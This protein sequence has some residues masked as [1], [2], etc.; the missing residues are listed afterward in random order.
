MW[1]LSSLLWIL[2]Q[3]PPKGLNVKVAIVPPTGCV[4]R[5]IGSQADGRLYSMPR[6]AL[7][8]YQY[9]ASFMP[10]CTVPVV[11]DPATLT[12]KTDGS[13]SITGG[14]THVHL[15][16][17]GPGAHLPGAIKGRVACVTAGGKTTCT[18]NSGDAFTPAMA[19]QMVNVGQAQFSGKYFNDFRTKCL[20]FIDA[21]HITISM[22]PKPWHNAA[23]TWTDQ[24]DSPIWFGP[25]IFRS[26][27]AGSTP[28]YLICDVAGNTF[29]L[30]Q[31]WIY[32]SDGSFTHVGDCTNPKVMR[33]RGS[34]I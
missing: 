32:A 34:N 20:T 30:R 11:A 5:L 15:I 8:G 22:D 28:E 4:P 13:Y 6:T 21:D 12:Y 9:L 23:T 2:A 26:G 29:T 25:M 31:K 10:Q 14:E 33:A 7:V 3:V 16:A 17:D 19:G 1:L 24:T 18:R 27:T